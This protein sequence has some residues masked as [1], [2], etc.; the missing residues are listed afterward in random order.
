MKACFVVSCSGEAAGFFRSM[1]YWFKPIK[2]EAPRFL[3]AT[4]ELEACFDS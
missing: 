2:I 3:E 1:S 4:K